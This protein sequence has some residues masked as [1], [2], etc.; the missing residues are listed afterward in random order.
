[1]R[2]LKQCELPVLFLLL[3]S[4]V[5]TQDRLIHDTGKVENLVD[6]V[7]GRDSSVLVV[8]G[9]GDLCFEETLLLICTS[10]HTKIIVSKLNALVK[11]WDVDFGTRFVTIFHGCGVY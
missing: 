8:E 1:M 5:Q 3:P 10:F 4:I 6:L 11:Y 9:N 2:Y 7:C